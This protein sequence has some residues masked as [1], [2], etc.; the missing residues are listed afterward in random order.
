MVTLYIV[1]LYNAVTRRRV[2]PQGMGNMPSASV[3]RPPDIPAERRAT[4][5]LFDDIWKVLKMN[6]DAVRDVLYSGL[7]KANEDK[8]CEWLEVFACL[9]EN[10]TESLLSAACEVADVVQEL[11]TGKIC[12]QNKIIGRCKRR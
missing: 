1:Q 7:M 8:L 3:F 4:D 10:Y 6:D 12:D 5:L 9:A 11:K 2:Q